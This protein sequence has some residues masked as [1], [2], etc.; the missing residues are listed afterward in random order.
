MISRKNAI[1]KIMKKA[2][3]VKLPKALSDPKYKGKHLLLVEGEVMAAGR[4]QSVSRALDK[5][6]ESGKTPQLTYIPKSDTLILNSCWAGV[7]A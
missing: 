6:I 2:T 1:L 7:S 5:V 3:L 4:W